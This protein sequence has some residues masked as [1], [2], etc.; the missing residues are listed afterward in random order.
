MLDKKILRSSF[1]R[2]YFIAAVFNFR[3]LQNIGLLYA[4]EP[5]LSAIYKDKE[6]LKAARA[7]YMWHF[8]THPL[9][10]PLLIGMFINLEQGV[11]RDSLPSQGMVALKNTACYTLS[12]IG[13][14]VFSGT[15]IPLWGIVM[16][17]LFV[18]GQV[19]IASAFLICA[20]LGVQMFRFV[21]YFAGLRHG[22]GVIGRLKNFDM[23]KW[24]QRIKI[25]NGSLLALLLYL[26]LPVPVGGFDLL[27][28]VLGF[29]AGGWL[30]FRCKFPRL[31]VYTAVFAVFWGADLVKWF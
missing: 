19:W 30:V 16:C 23:M 7:R 20:V 21:T 17:C 6:Q 18:C 1:F 28:T 25:L 2:S 15:L 5:A 3:G 31:L 13:D 26:V 24:G 8:N 12:G 10:V 14:S 9:W 29:G 11:S 4:M 27:V 22:L